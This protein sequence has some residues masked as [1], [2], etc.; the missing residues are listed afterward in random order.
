MTGSDASQISPSSY[1]QH[2]SGSTYF[3]VIRR[4]N[5]C[6]CQED[7]LAAAVKVAIDAGGDLVQP[8]PNNIFDVRAEQ[9][10]GSKVQIV[11]YYCPVEQKSEPACFKVY[12]DGG[13][14]QINYE[15][16]IAI[17]S[18]LGRK[19]YNY[20]SATLDAGRYLFAVR[21]EDAA[22]TE[23]CSLAQIKIQLDTTSPGAINILNAEA[24]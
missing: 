6:G 4:A 3:Y 9:V 10:A 16:P 1:V 17:I 2:N 15:N 21:A 20:H 18:Y 19:F 7:T 11:W 24:V 5:N 8:Q 23:N 12:C 13:T 22:G 14:G